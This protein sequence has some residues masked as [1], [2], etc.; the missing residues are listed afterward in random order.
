ME[1]EREVGCI[2]SV[3]LPGVSSQG[4]G[5]WVQLLICY[6]FQGP[7]KSLSPAQNQM[8]DQLKR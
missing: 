7:E 2:L 8:S 5:V 3:T 4:Q 6:L 1:R